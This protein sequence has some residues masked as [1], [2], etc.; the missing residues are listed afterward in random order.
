MKDDKKLAAIAAV[1][2]GLVSGAATA[3]GFL[4]L[5]SVPAALAVAI[6][7][8]GAL[9]AAAM[10]GGGAALAVG[11]VVG[12]SVLAY[13]KMD[14]KELASFL[15][16]IVPSFVAGAGVAYA[17]IAATTLGIVAATGIGA[18]VV[19]AVLLTVGVIAFYK[20]Q[21]AQKAQKALDVERKS[22][23][24]Q[25]PFFS[26]TRKILLTVTSVEANDDV[27]TDAKVSSDQFA[28]STAV[29]ADTTVVDTNANVASTDQGDAN[30]SLLDQ[31]V[32]SSDNDMFG[33]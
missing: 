27:V 19:T 1:V 23:N 30:K 16:S 12:L 8:V 2:S 25:N 22:A 32:E 5:S 6:G 15:V 33:M 18:G 21:K 29:V 7:G 3:V 31:V 14:S 20:A 26:D 24:L 17:L 4:E 28:P 13:K 10:I 9:A 11:L